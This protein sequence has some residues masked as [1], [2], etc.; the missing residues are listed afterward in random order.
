[1]TRVRET[2]VG[3]LWVCARKTVDRARHRPVAVR[4]GRWVLAVRARAGAAWVVGA[5]A[6]ARALSAHWCSHEVKQSQVHQ[7]NTVIFLG[8]RFAHKPTKGPNLA[9]CFRPPPPLPTFN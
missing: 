4:R 8:A 3:S 5:V 9:A 1:M 2:S 7:D 6:A